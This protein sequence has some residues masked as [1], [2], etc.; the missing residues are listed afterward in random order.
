MNG[1]NLVIVRGGGDLATGTIARLRQ[2]GFPVVV[3]EVPAPSASRQREASSPG[4]RR[5][6]RSTLRALLALA[7]RS[8]VEAAI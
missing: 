6:R 5:R 3:L 7:G 8:P 2:C 1:N 4:L